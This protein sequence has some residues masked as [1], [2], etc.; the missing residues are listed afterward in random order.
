MSYSVHTRWGAAEIAP[1]IARMRE[2]LKELDP[3]DPEH[4]DVS[5]TH[6]S[7]WTLSIFESGLVVWEDIEAAEYKPRHMIDVDRERALS[8]WLQLSRGDLAA[9]E[10]QPWQPGAFPP[11][12]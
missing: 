11:I 1:S 5:L 3:A 9:I 6:E 7:G 8:M 12:D 4:P 2:I 10:Q